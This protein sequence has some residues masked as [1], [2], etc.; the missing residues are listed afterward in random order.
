MKGMFSF[1]KERTMPPGRWR[2]WV[3]GRQGPSRDVC[4]LRAVHSQHLAAVNRELIPCSTSKGFGESLTSLNIVH[5]WSNVCLKNVFSK[6]LCRYPSSK[7]TNIYFCFLIQNSPS[8]QSK[9]GAQFPRLDSSLVRKHDCTVDCSW[10][11]SGWDN[12]QH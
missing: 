8:M 5:W 4:T 10:H 1:R 12:Q 9:S 11:M 3:G 2:G 7:D 6:S